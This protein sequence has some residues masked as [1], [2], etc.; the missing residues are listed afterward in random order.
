MECK[1]SYLTDVHATTIPWTESPLFEK[2]LEHEQLPPDL[3]KMVRSFSND[4]YLIIDPEVSESALDGA[5]SDL[6]GTF[7]GRI[8]DAWQQSHHVKTIATAP[9]VLEVL[10]LLY[11]R[12]PIPFQTL[13]FNVGT[14]QAT[15]SD[16]I[17]FHCIP[18]RFMCGVWV[19][20][21]DID[22]YNGPLH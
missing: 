7:Q 2:L 11:R 21:E 3:E 14:E 17:H 10:S 9:K 16:A 12:L 1:N 20:L 8:Q 13:N 19:E 5:I 22:E 18:E 6:A 4:G 15:H